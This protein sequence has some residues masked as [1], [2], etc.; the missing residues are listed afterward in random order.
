MLPH[1]TR[2]TWAKIARTIIRESTFITSLWVQAVHTVYIILIWL[3][4]WEFAEIRVH[5]I[6]CWSETLI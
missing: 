3:F 1:I 5:T 2:L 4:Y 6:F